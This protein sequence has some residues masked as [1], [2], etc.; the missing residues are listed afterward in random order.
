MGSFNASQSVASTPAATPPRGSQQSG[1]S[2]SFT[3]GVPHNAMPR[4]GFGGYDE[5]NGYG[6]MM[7]YQEEYKPQIYR[8][9]L[10]NV[11]DRLNAQ[12]G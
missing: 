8:V 12:N 4:S 10:I 1:M 7:P 6:A 3:N 11:F 5:S 2:Y 9:G